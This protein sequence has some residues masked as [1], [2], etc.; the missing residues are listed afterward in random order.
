MEKMKTRKILYV[1][2]IAFLLF[3]VV[4]AQEETELMLC[5]KYPDI[6]A[7]CGQNDSP[8]EKPPVDYIL[9]EGDYDVS[10]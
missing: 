10:A 8:V 3:S 7:L 5:A 6:G 1:G 4:S 2:L 9:S